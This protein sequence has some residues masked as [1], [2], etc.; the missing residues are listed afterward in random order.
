M[1]SGKIP[2]SASQEGGLPVAS[3]LAS[4]WS[5][6]ILPS[7]VFESTDCVKISVRRKWTVVKWIGQ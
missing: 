6:R 5:Q 2:F 3:S 4:S 7:N 1:E